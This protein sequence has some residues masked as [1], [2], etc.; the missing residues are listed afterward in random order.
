LGVVALYNSVYFEKLDAKKAQDSIKNFNPADRA[1]YFWE[2][3]LDEILTSAID[4]E[5]FDSQLEAN[6]ESLIRQ[7][8]KAIGLTSTYCFL[9]QGSATQEPGSREIPVDMKDGYADYTLLTKYIFG[10]A[11][12]DATGYFN[13]DDFDNTMDFNAVATELNKLVLEREIPKLDSL[14]AGE[15]IKF[16]GALEI[17]SENIPGQIGIIPLKIKAA[18]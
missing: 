4:L 17:N 3:E 8:G 16:V 15:T 14:S 1:K 9:V 11:A 13:I 12:R 18:R 5:L 10:N 2:H 7:H 6:P